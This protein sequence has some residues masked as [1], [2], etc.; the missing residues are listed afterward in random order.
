MIIYSFSTEYYP[1]EYND[2][3][4][5]QKLAADLFCK[6]VSCLHA[7]PKNN[8]RGSIISLGV[9]FSKIYVGTGLCGAT[10]IKSV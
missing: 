5:V 4:V 8:S 2:C 6:L 10:H 1:L 9:I 3:R 7:L